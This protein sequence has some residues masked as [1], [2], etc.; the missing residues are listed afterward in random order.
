VN[1]FVATS[2]VPALSVSIITNADQGT[3]LGWEAD[4]P[5]YCASGTASPYGCNSQVPAV[6]TYGFATTVGG[7]LA[8]SNSGS[9]AFWPVL[10]AQDGSFYGT[11]DNGD[12]V[13]ATSS[14]SPLWSVPNDSPQLATADGGVISTS[15]AP[16]DGQGRATRQI[17]NMPTYA[18]TGDA[19]QID[20]G[21]A[22]QISSA[23]INMALD[24][25]PMNL[26]NNSL[27]STAF[28]STVETLYLR[29]FAPWQLFGPELDPV[30]FSLKYICIQNCFYG[31]N[32]SF[33][34]STDGSVTSRTTK[35]VSFLVPG[36]TVYNDPPPSSDPSRDIFGRTATGSPT[37]SATS[38]GGKIHVQLMGSNP[39][40]LA[41]KIVTQMDISS[42]VGNGQVC[43]SGKVYGDQFPNAES[44]VINSQSQPVMLDEFST[45][46]SPNLGPFA[47]LNPI[48]LLPMGTFSNIC[49]TP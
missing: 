7:G 47:L 5:E 21:Q 40:A 10:Q 46:F 25:W 3:A 42:K 35:I 16:Y 11:D 32:R 14:G 26:A 12:M 45:P 19:Y 31:D 6:S 22:E 4:A 23:P 37:G 28:K 38:Q 2:A 43:Y 13:H 1:T 15:G 33:S 44:F 29:S 34:T 49:I 9:V 20:P 17:A 41:P 30:P 36:M 39:L 24:F 27:N 18:W 48:N 8:S